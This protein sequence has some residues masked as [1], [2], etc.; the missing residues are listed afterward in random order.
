MAHFYGTLN[1][2]RGEASR[3]GDKGSGLTAY[4]ASWSGAIKTTMYVNP[5][6]QDCFKVEEVEWEG[7]GQRR[8]LAEGVLGGVPVP[9]KYAT[10][11]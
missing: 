5:K 4:A 11:V 6:G 7:K 3:C 10:V 8:L 9:G 1:G 2:S